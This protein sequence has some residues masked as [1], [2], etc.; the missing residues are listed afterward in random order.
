MIVN[1]RSTYTTGMT[2]INIPSS[3]FLTQETRQLI[4]CLLLVVHLV[5]MLPGVYI[6]MSL[7]VMCRTVV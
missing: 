7:W 2:H 6:G 3:Y 4:L 1:L 5:Y